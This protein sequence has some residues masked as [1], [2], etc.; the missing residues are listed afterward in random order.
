[1]LM[2]KNLNYDGLVTPE[3]TPVSANYLFVSLK[4]L[5]LLQNSSVKWPELLCPCIRINVSNYTGF[6]R[7]SE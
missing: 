4:Q 6:A 2:T 1:M 5:V 3:V 7:E